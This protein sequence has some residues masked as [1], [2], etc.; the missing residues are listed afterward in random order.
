[1]EPARGTCIHTHAHTHPRALVEN[2]THPPATRCIAVSRSSILRCQS[3]VACTLREY[4]EYEQTWDE[5]RWETRRNEA[6]RSEPRRG[7]ARRGETRNKARIEILRNNTGF[8]RFSYG[9]GFTTRRTV[10]PSPLSAAMSTRQKTTLDDTPR[11]DVH[12][13]LNA[14]KRQT[15]PTDTA[16]YHALPSDSPRFSVD[17]ALPS[18]TPRSPTQP[19]RTHAP[20]VCTDECGRT[21]P[22]RAPSAFRFKDEKYD[23]YSRN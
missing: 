1:M 19:R 4:G 13:F 2:N 22:I 10:I 3:T 23:R 21:A 7:E 8:E 14:A 16:T 6:R 9:R 12:C 17:P 20:G 11:R 5:T 18:R 15:T